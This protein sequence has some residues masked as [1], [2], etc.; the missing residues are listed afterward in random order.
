MYVRRIIKTVL[1]IVAG[2]LGLIVLAVVAL[3]FPL[4]QRTIVQK[5]LSS[6]SEETHTRIEVGSVNIFITNSIVLHNIFIES[7]Q[8]DTL[9]SIQTL[10]ADVNLLGFFSNDIKLNNVRIDSLT[11]HITRTLPDSSFNFDFILNAISPH[12]ATANI[13]PDTISGS[14]WKIRFGRLS[15]NGVHGTYD[16]EVSGLNLRL[17]LGTLDASLN[18]F[19]IEKKQFRVD[20]LSLANTIASVIQTKESPPD[21]SKSADIDLGVGALSL[22]KV[23]FVYENT[24]TRERYGV[25]LGTSTLLAEKIDIPSHHVALKK[26]LLENTNIVVV[27][28]NRKENKIEK[29]DATVLPWVISLDQLILSGN[30]VQ[31]DVQ[32]AARTKGVDPNHLR[33]DGLTMRAEN[34][35]FSENR[36]KADIHHTSFREHSG[37]DV[38]ELS[39]GLLLDSLHAQLTNFMV[40]T[41]V[42]R[43]RQNIILGYSSLAELK[44]LQ[45]TVKVKVT[46]GDSYLA[47]SDLL[48]FQPSLP[49]KN[50]PGLLIRFTS[51]LSGLVGDL[52]VEEFRAT[53]GDSTTIDLTGS[54]RGL[55]EIE[56]AH[57][58]VNLHR[59][60][61]GRTDI[62]AIIVDTL[63][64]KDI[65]IP[66]TM[67][68]SGN[69]KGTLKNFSTSSIIET[70]FGSVKGNVELNSGGGTN[71][72][73]SRWKADVIVE[74]FNIGSL[75]NDPETFG[76]VSLKA[77]AVG[78][79][80]NKDDIEAQLNVQV[81]KAVVNGYPYR[82]LSI[83]GTASPKMFEGKAEIQDSNI[84]FIF[85]GTVN[86]GE[87][88]PTYKFTFDLKG[89]DLHQL[90]FTPDDIRMAGSVTSD[91]TGQDIN[92]INGTIDVRNVVIIKNRDRYSIDSLVCTSVNKEGQAHIGIESTIFSAQFD[93]TI[94][95]GDL[96]EVLKEHFTQY[97]NLHGERHRKNLK[98]QAFTFHITLHDPTALT[99]LLVP[100]LHQLSAGTITGNYNSDKKNLNVNIN[101]P[102]VDY[103]DFKIDSLNLIV[104]SDAD[105]LKAK[106]NVVSITDS[107]FRVTNLQFAGNAGHDSIE[108]VLQSTRNDG[109]KK[110]L[111]A[112]EFHS[113]PE[114]YKLQ[115]N[116]DGVVFQ[117]Q[118]WDVSFDN[119]LLFGK[120]QFIAHNVVLRNAGQSLSLNSTDEKSQ[121]SPLK[122]EF[123]N[124]NL[125]T[126]SQVVERDSGMLGGILTG[127]VV[128]QNLE[129][130]KAFTS[131]LTIRDFSFGQKLIG[132]VVLRANNQTENVYEVNMD[133]TGNGNQIAMQGKYRSEEGTSGLD[134][135]CD[136][137]KVNLASIEPFTF[138]NV[139][140]LSGTMTGGLHVTGT[141][142][143]PS[144][145]GELNFI[146][147]AFVLPFLDTYQHLNNGK[148]DI[149]ARGV[150]F[151]SFDLVD[152]LGNKASLS[153][154][155]FTEDFRNYKYDF[156]MHTDKFLLLNKPASRDALYYG[157]VV[158]DSDISVKG[159]Q[160]RPI[161]TMQAE[162]DKG[163]NLALV[164]PESELAVEERRGI[165]RFVDTKTPPNSIMS[166]Q[167][168]M[169]D[170]DTTE[171]KL[172]SLLSMD[173]T[174]NITVNKE[175][176]L[177]ILIDPIA[178]DSLVIQ[179]E[180]TLSFAIDP[181]GKL[182][183]T[184]R[185]EI[186]K[187]SYQLSF[188]GLIK[189][190]FAIEEGSSLTWLGS[191]YEADVDITAMYTVKT[192]VLDL[193]QDQLAGISQ[194]E[195]NKYKQEIP[196]QVYLIM[197]GKLLKP[198]IHFKLD[199]PSDQRGVLN[200]T[201]YAKINEL[202][203]QESEL[204]KQVFALLV[205]GR[206]V[207][208]NPLASAVGNEGISDYA[209]SSVSQ[210]LSAQLNHLS[211][212]YLAGAN[213]NVGLES[214]Q[215]YSS[216]TAEGRTQLKL[217]L[218][219][220]LFSERVTVQ[221]GGDV[222]LEGRRS[223]ENSLNNF[224]G[225]LKVLYKLTEDGH[226][227]LQVFRQNTY[228]GVI[229]GDITKTGAG[230][231]FTIDFEKLLGITLKP[232][233]DKEVK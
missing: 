46:I 71:L 226:W 200:G 220:Q 171:E 169:S 24:V 173:L 194:E 174:S 100:E 74:E 66:A 112:G 222:D 39:G 97:F 126:I 179:G 22:T 109:F 55:P 166:R 65:V 209:R 63:L 16:D 34:I 72:K 85:N 142:K 25:D 186:L 52:Q 144:M 118:P 117:N 21:E 153:G 216:G 58:D 163:T 203:G 210:I 89:A 47:I 104:T 96:P 152:T 42:S 158:L 60:S 94:A 70:S 68:V 157:T 207:S 224:G 31:Y 137:T 32:D 138:G 199:L 59:F 4:V 125:A 217:A 196:I 56:T 81:D 91:L 178:G 124:F 119:Y 147:T 30:S 92:D 29:S 8:R 116:K 206:F 182:T 3:Q 49:I 208:E 36:M 7:R 77:S 130:R 79:G 78:T 15:L 146:N 120:N 9:L 111:L 6:I 151:R 41:A 107:T 23:Y 114:G 88:N 76:P 140:R 195:R 121:R 127:N 86:A 113:V 141:T 198:D 43:I 229:D 87:N 82:R 197:K 221:V 84:A 159:D 40:E 154:H 106:L 26:F 5:A 160:S 225:D 90:N 122:V 155:L 33:L 54:I 211:E 189:R 51:Q 184:G 95:A 215:D 219:K 148:I 67:S 123:N 177:R 204:N 175:S 11:A 103:N 28:P 202:N 12:P 176:K 135:M 191:P 105:L 64:P 73:T 170:R 227:Q 164:M 13:N 139:Q 110:I 223:Q 181:S 50:T 93:G 180:A 132:D 149:D 231:V 98:A 128:L 185:Y 20:E 161:V 48:F 37:L 80:L 233:S 190:E 102:R 218:S 136:F 44:N 2:I 10:T 53:V 133:I 18:N 83:I 193:V 129:K 115:L 228:E 214:Y 45:G 75:L 17:Q 162:L 213:L 212:Q 201:V 62:Q 69:F 167:A 192:A 143:K 35:Y 57:Y 134:L 131:D 108:V 168:V 101:I 232:D 61:S 150:E 183:L 99:D 14:G 188:E 156:R 145:S 19:D 172:L 27:Q 1:W 187:G 205:L 230:V 38:R 165:V